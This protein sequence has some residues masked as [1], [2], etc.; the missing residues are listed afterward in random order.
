MNNN[1]VTSRYLV[2]AASFVI[3]IAGLRAASALAVPFLLATFFAIVLSPWMHLLRKKGL[4]SSLALIVII[5]V[6]IAISGSL[7]YLI[8]SS[9]NQF[10]QGLAD[11]PNRIE[12]NL[13]PL[14]EQWFAEWLPLGNP[15]D[16]P[17]DETTVQ[18][19]T[20]PTATQAHGTRRGV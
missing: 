4:P 11:L 2:I 20:P 18:D 17:E 12:R 3:V 1:A 15:P 14:R 10:R 13:E 5:G 9:I 16:E 6:C 19:L 8:G 7:S